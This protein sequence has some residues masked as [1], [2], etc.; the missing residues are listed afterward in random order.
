MP[1]A[2]RVIGQFSP[3]RWITH[4]IETVQKS[5]SLADALPDIALVLAFSVLLYIIGMYRSRKKVFGGAYKSKKQQ[6]AAMS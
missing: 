1:K 5:G 3:Q 6:S 4:A 2:F